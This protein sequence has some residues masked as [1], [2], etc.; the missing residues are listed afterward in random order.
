MRALDLHGARNEQTKPKPTERQN[1][2]TPTETK[3]GK[4][5]VQRDMTPDYE[6]EIERDAARTETSKAQHS[7]LPWQSGRGGDN[8]IRIYSNGKPTHLNVVAQLGE[9]IDEDWREHKHASAN[10]KLIVASVNH[11]DKLAESLRAL[12]TNFVTVDSYPNPSKEISDKFIDLA[13]SETLARKVL[14]AYDKGERSAMTVTQIKDGSQWKDSKSH[15]DKLAGALR[16]ALNMI[17]PFVWDK[18]KEAAILDA[19]EEVEKST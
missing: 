16:N 18:S 11:A 7:P 9:G 5:V 12:L 3:Q 15:A 1:M 4:V 8:T 17:D 10:A 13:T 6:R 2:K 19:Y 14:A